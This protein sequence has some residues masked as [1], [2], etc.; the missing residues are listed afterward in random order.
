M[1]NRGKTRDALLIHKMYVV[2]LKTKEV[3]LLR[4]EDIENKS[5]SIIKISESYNCTIKHILISQELY[6]EMIEF[7]NELCDPITIIN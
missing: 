2:E 7:K 4:F 5:Q 1:T 3:R 6:E